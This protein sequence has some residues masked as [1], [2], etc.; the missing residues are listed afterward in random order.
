[1]QKETGSYCTYSIPGKTA[2]LV[3]EFVVENLPSTE[4]Q[5]WVLLCSEGPA[6]G[7]NTAAADDD[8]CN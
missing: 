8:D 4:L 6:L 1:M 7:Q 5:P 2:A 3:P